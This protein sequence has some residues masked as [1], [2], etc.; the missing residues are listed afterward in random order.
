LDDLRGLFQPWWFYDSLCLYV[1][2]LS[3]A[4][5]SF[6]VIPMRV[7]QEWHHFDKLYNHKSCRS[8]IEFAFIDD[9]I[10]N[11]M[12][13][14]DSVAE[15][16]VSTCISSVIL[17]LPCSRCSRQSVAIVSC[18][19]AALYNTCAM[20]ESDLFPAQNIANFMHCTQTQ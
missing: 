3:G 11:L 16:P 4:V 8:I 14:L 13:D 2:I 20:L 6:K 10:M 15:R 19:P 5:W 7:L 17:P 12:Y 1:D 9:S 18:E